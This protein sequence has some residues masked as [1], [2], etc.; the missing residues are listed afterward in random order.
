M[1]ETLSFSCNCR[2][3][4]REVWGVKEGGRQIHHGEIKR[5]TGRGKLKIS[6]LLQKKRCHLEPKRENPN[7]EPK[8]VIPGT[9]K[10]SPMWTAAEPLWN[11]F[12]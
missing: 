5:K 9:R 1:L 10:G 12:V 11:P 7:M 8:I 3:R 6:V 2:P 4:G